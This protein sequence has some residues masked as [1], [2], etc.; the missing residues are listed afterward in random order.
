M[1]D[2]DVSITSATGETSFVRMPDSGI[3]FIGVTGTISAGAIVVVVKVN[4]GSTEFVADTIDATTL[5]AN[6]NEAGTGYSY[7][8]EIAVPPN[9]SVALKANAAF[10]GSV[11][12]SVAQGPL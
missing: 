5:L 4:G 3:G 2:Q 7:F 1:A 11:T 8:E 9:A 10:T 12:V 6:G